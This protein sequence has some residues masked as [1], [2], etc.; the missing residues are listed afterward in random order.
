MA[1]KFSSTS[2]IITAKRSYS[3]Q[4]AAKAAAPALAGAGLQISK[5]ASG[6]VVAS[7]E[8]DSPIARVAV[9][10]RGG[11]RYDTTPGVSHMLRLCASA[12]LS[13]T[14]RTGFN[15]QRTLQQIGATLNVVSDREVAMYA[16]ASNRDS[17]AETLS[18]LASL[19]SN[20]SYRYYELPNPYLSARLRAT[21]ELSAEDRVVDLLGKAAFRA[22]PLGN[23]IYVPPYNVDK[24]SSDQLN[25]FVSATHG[26]AGLVVVGTGVDHGVLVSGA[27]AVGLS[28]GS[29]PASTPTKYLGGDLRH[30]TGGSVANVA[31]AGEGAKLGGSDSIVAEVAAQVLGGGPCVKYGANS[32]SVLVRALQ[33]DT[34]AKIV[35]YSVSFSDAGLLGFSVKASAAQAPKVIV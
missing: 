6:A 11:S 29:V 21:L 19:T 27:E 33:G 16:L 32:S 22:Q 9:F 24:I 18:L 5:L 28:G 7:V 13:S 1:T 8:N 34:S 2:L 4:A 10:L 3:A 26:A 20:N 14:Q 31:I 25:A 12:G 15:M 17:V 23:S 35:G 30:E